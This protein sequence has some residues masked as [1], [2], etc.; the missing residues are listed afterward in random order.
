MD[1]PWVVDMTTET[2]KMAAED[3]DGLMG[4]VLD[5]AWLLRENDPF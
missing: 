1:S 2:S 3:A 5:E 4:R